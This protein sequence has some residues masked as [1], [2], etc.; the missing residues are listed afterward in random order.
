MDKTRY[1]GRHTMPIEF[2]EKAY[3]VPLVVKD[4]VGRLID[5]AFAAGSDLK[6]IKI[7]TKVVRGNFITEI[8]GV[9]LEDK[10]LDR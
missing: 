5:E 9:N 7:T 10:E 2:L 6:D 1:V 3:S 8:E 4:V